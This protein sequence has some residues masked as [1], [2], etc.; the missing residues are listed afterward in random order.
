MKRQVSLAIE[1]NKL[2]KPV[3]IKINKDL[4]E[5]KSYFNPKDHNFTLKNINNLELE[6][7]I[8][9]LGELLSEIRS[10][11]KKYIK[12]NSLPNNKTGKLIKKLTNKI[13]KKL[14]DEKIELNL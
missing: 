4:D 1:R 11:N 10:T 7:D 5:L 2:Y 6:E 13:K 8:V 14:F 3:M 9:K 12:Y